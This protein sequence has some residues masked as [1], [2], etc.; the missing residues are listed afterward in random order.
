[1]RLAARATVKKA[2]IVVA[3]VL[4]LAYLVASRSLWFPDLERQAKVGRDRL[5]RTIDITHPQTITWAI[6]GDDWKYTGECHVALILDRI[7]DAPSEAYRRE[8]MALKVR[9]DAHAVTYQPT[10]ARKTIEGIRA[11]RLIRNW[12]FT[13]DTPLSADA[14]I[15]ESWGRS[16]EIGLC[17]VRRYPWEDTYIE[18]EVLQPDLLLAKANPRLQIFGE[19]DYA[20]YEHIIILRIIRD[21]V[22]LFLA[23]CVLGV[24]Y[25]ALKQI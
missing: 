2:L 11:P 1:V 20:V 10:T 13:T 5:S 12:Y 7:K 24:T 15:W 19:H 4:V 14:R 16:V 23:L 25:A 17:G 18:V 9:V 8:S 3:A 21:G 22:L 6:K